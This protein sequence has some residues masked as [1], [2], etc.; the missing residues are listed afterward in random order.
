MLDVFS[1]PPSG[2][3]EAPQDARLNAAGHQVALR[4][5]KLNYATNEKTLREQLAVGLSLLHSSVDTWE[6][7]LQTLTSDEIP[8]RYGILLLGYRDFRYRLEALSND[9]DHVLLEAQ[10]IQA[11]KGKQM[12]LLAAYAETNPAHF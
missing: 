7:L 9:L 6:N 11:S 5:V 12:Y 2:I 10:R 4:S 1:Q 3:Q 8:D